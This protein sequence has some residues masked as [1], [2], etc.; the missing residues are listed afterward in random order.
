MG[1]L[2]AQ[3]GG[4][5]NTSTG[6]SCNLIVNGNAEAATGSADGTPV[7][8]PGWASTGGATAAQYGVDGWRG[9]PALTD[10]GPPDRGLNLFSGGPSD[11]LS[12]LTQI[13]NVSQF[14]SS[15]DTGHVT[16]ALS[17]WLGGWEDQGDNATLTVTFQSSTG[18]ALG[19]GSIG[20]VTPANRA[21]ATGLLQRS[22]NGQVP[23]GTRN[24]LV[25][26][27]MV[28]TDGTANDGYADDLSL[29]FS[30]LA[31]TS[32]VPAC[33]SNG[34][35]PTGAGG[36]NGGTGGS[37]SGGGA[38]TVSGDTTSTGG[39][40][41][42]GGASSG[43][44]DGSASTDG[45][46]ETQA[47]QAARTSLAAGSASV[48]VDCAQTLKYTRTL[49]SDGSLATEEIDDTVHG[50]MA[51]WD[52]RSP[53]RTY[54]AYPSRAATV[55]AHSMDVTLVPTEGDP[56]TDVAATFISTDDT[57]GNNIPDQRVTWV[58]DTSSPTVSI[59]VETDPTESGSWSV[60]YTGT[61][62]RLQQSLMV[63]PT[64]PPVGCTA[65]DAK[66]LTDTFDPLINAG[67]ACLK[68]MDSDLGKKFYEFFVDDNNVTVS[69]GTQTG[70]CG[71]SDLAGAIYHWFPGDAPGQLSITIAPNGF[72]DPAH[73]GALS[74]TLFH[75]LMHFFL[76]PHKIGD[77]MPDPGDRIYNCEKTCFSPSE[78][79][80][81]TCAACLGSKNGDSRCNAY[82]QAPCDGSAPP[83]YCPCGDGNWYA[84]SISCA[85]GC[86]SGLA[87]FAVQ[88]QT[89]NGPCQ[90]GPLQ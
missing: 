20:P 2:C 71:E 30:G 24:V 53:T 18:S 29:V 36:S 54:R 89:T 10:P 17:G 56:A 66:A 38:T 51:V 31:A 64:P 37:V 81:Q 42:S 49:G 5:S 84:D 57:T 69:C 40:T 27:V 86:G 68:A 85:V 41:S 28:F 87:C 59:T 45:C 12:S 44:T 15:I 47:I 35:Q 76:G 25:S 6:S 11:A 21:N 88:C 26:L 1:L 22:S 43:G 83:A 50:D 62:P 70:F 67:A 75:E 74:S 82:P 46:T 72:A 77:G 23:S 78:A 73:C 61:E 58:V 79:N 32:A 34:S 60:V 65:D 14:A 80:S 63:D 33:P 16:Y 52:F 4:S 8:T 19:T 3:C 39:T 48:F 13:V 90:L 7:P 55:A 9:W